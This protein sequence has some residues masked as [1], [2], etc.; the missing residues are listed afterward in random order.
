MT[1]TFK[2][3]RLGTCAFLEAFFTCSS[4]NNLAFDLCFN[5]KLVSDTQ[6]ELPVRHSVGA[7]SACQK[8]WQPQVF[9][10]FGRI[11]EHLCRKISGFPFP[12]TC[13]LNPFNCLTVEKWI[14]AAFP[15]LSQ[16]GETDSSPSLLVR[17]N[18]LYCS[19]T[20]GSPT[21]TASSF[22]FT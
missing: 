20:P 12:L 11:K 10:D 17:S 1:G 13:T 8:W 22:L 14:A 18:Q 4:R 16:W 9:E 3:N 5:L 6:Q 15:W 19:G 7:V 2:Q 21:C